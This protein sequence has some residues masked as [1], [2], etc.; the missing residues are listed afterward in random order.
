MQL[1]RDSVRAYL[2]RIKLQFSVSSEI[3]IIEH[4]SVSEALQ[5]LVIEENIDLI[6]M[7][8]HGH[9]GRYHY[10]YGS[11]AREMLEFG[12]RPLLIIQDVPR[13][14]VQPSDSEIASKKIEGRR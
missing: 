3:R 11:V 8:A 4:R 6:I 13:H 9:T 12:S 1:T 5:G 7:S 10:P 14:L 2:E